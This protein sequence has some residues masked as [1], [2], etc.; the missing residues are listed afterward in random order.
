MLALAA[1]V[2]LSAVISLISEL[3]AWH[4]VYR[5][6]DYQ[7]FAR[8]ITKKKSQIAEE[9]KLYNQ[10]GKKVHAS[11]LKKHEQQYQRLMRDGT[12]KT[13]KA[14]LIPTLF[15]VACMPVVLP[16]LRGIVV[17][18]LPFAPFWIFKSIAHQGL[19]E[20]EVH[21][22]SAICIFFLAV[23]A[24]RAVMRKAMPVPELPR[25]FEQFGQEVK[26]D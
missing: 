8:D 3:I 6:A 11:R 5:K 10:T 4:W 23:S 24:F 1:I 13:V 14:Q 9:T 17:A 12:M 25:L 2:T 19:E 15:A 26:E 20:P 7:E 22:C 16:Y 21:D 18:K